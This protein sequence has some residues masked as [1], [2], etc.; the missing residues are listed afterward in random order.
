MSCQ[1]ANRRPLIAALVPACFAVGCAILVAGSAASAQ[2]IYE[3]VQYQYGDQHERFY[4]GGSDPA[5]FDLADRTRCRYI[6]GDTYGLDGYNGAYL[7]PRRTNRFDLVFWDCVPYLN[8]SPFGY[9]RTH[10]R[11]DAYLNVPRYFRKGDLV[12][13]A[14]VLGDGTRVVPAQHR[15]PPSYRAERTDRRSTT[16]PTTRRIIIIP[17]RAPAP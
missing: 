9:T 1:S 15:P 6:R 11:N 14:P 16:R 4:Y 3:P 13:T 5:V 8:A 17:K 7:H 10:A 2:T 12:E